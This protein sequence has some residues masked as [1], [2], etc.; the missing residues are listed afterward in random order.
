MNTAGSMDG[1]GYL[2]W[3]ALLLS[4]HLFIYIII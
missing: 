2:H 4:T 1:V 3:M